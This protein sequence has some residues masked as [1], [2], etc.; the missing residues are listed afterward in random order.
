MRVLLDPDSAARGLRRMAGEIV[1]RHRGAEGLVIVGIRRGGVLVAEALVRFLKELESRDVPVGT[2]DITL[3]RDDA[4][5]AL[6]NPRIGPSDIPFDLTS[7][8]VIL[9]DDVV[10]T[11]RTVRAALDALMDYGRPHRIQ[12]AALVDRGG[13]ELPVQPDY[14]VRRVELGA[15]ERVDVI[16]TGSQLSAVVQ[17]KN[18]PSIPPEA[19]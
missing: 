17:P 13:R 9:V 6:P 1:E 7:K 8:D 10:Y 14:V 11:G 16:A 5:T 2:V 19:P 15:D 12:L 3:Y 18:A 4:A